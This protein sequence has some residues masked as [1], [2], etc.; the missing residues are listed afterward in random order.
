[1][2]ERPVD[3][4]NEN[5]KVTNERVALTAM[6]ELVAGLMDR[7]MHTVEIADLWRDKIEPGLRRPYAN[8]AENDG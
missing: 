7:G 5:Q 6:N 8:K 2:T 4:S 3:P 1:M